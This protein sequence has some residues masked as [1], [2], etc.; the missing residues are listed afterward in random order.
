MRV[1]TGTIKR[2]VVEDITE[3]RCNRCEHP[4]A[5]TSAYIT[6]RLDKMGPMRG[7]SVLWLDLCIPCYRTITGV[8]GYDVPQS[9]WLAG[10]TI[11]VGQRASVVP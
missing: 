7:V 8:D 4:I 2:E 10:L 11:E 3:L 5:D 9:A 6:V 1:K